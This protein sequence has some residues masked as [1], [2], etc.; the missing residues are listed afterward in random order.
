[1]NNQSMTFLDG[2]QS[3]V[4]DTRRHQLVEVTIDSLAELGHV[5]TTLAQIAMR[6]GVSPGLVAQYFGD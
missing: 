2:S 4:E 5:G 6:A 1:M 3:P